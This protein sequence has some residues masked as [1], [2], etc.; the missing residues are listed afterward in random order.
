MEK[1]ISL[2]LTSLQ[3][4]EL[5]KIEKYSAGVSLVTL[6]SKT[7][8]IWS[9]MLSN[10]LGVAD[11]RAHCT[12]R[13]VPL[14]VAKVPPLEHLAPPFSPREAGL[15]S[16]LHP[17]FQSNAELLC[18][19]VSFLAW[20]P[21]WQHTKGHFNAPFTG[22]II[23]ILFSPPRGAGFSIHSI[24]WICL[25]AAVLSFQV[26]SNDGKFVNYQKI[27]EQQLAK[28]KGGGGGGEEVSLNDKCFWLNPQTKDSFTFDIWKGETGTSDQRKERENG[29]WEAPQPPVWD[30]HCQGL[31]FAHPVSPDCSAGHQELKVGLVWSDGSEPKN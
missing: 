12:W 14:L 23:R 6:E 31:T 18:G 28:L 27:K 8:I 7:L 15:I 4:L 1:S 10:N 30:T 16:F 22:L 24:S 5:G 3:E 29:S 21:P 17:L 11:T 9:V 2:T 26:M 25:R 13:A 19:T 20:N